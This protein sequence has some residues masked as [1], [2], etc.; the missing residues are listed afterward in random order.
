[1][2]ISFLGVSLTRSFR[3][4][5]FAHSGRAIHYKSSHSRIFPPL[6]VGFSLLSLTQLSL[7]NYKKM[8]KVEK[9]KTPN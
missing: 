9:Q 4:A 6:A 2:A 8:L 3:C 5:S 7:Q 1:M